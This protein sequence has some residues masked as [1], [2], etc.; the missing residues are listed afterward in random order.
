MCQFKSDDYIYYARML[1]F[2]EESKELLT[3]IKNHSSI[4][5]ISKL[6]DARNI[7]T[8]QGLTMLESDIQAAHIYDTLVTEKYHAAT[9][10]EYSREIV[11]V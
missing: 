2:R 5:L 1:G 6:A 9:T 10:S 4:P 11:R 7:L 3:E 8:E